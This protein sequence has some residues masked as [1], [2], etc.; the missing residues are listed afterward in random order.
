MLY[1]IRFAYKKGS[2]ACELSSCELLA[3]YLIP[4]T[5]VHNSLSFTF[6]PKQN[7]VASSVFKPMDHVLIGAELSGGVKGGNLKYSLASLV[8]AGN[9]DFG[10]RASQDLNT[11]VVGGNMFVSLKEGTVETV[12]SVSHSFNS[13]NK[14]ALMPSVTLVGKQQYNKNVCYK[15]SFN[16]AMLFKATAGYKVND[17]LTAYTGFAFDPAA[18]AQSDR[19]KFGFRWVVQK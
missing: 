12:A 9:V 10:V 16:D 14:D 17:L 8:S 13:P 4:K 19:L 3:E 5:N 18:K 7:F 6:A 1:S 2:H 15:A 11:G